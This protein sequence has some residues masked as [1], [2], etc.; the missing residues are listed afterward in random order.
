MVRLI[1]D[2]RGGR[3]IEPTRRVIPI[4][5]SMHGALKAFESSFG[6]HEMG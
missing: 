1:D 2:H 6:P 5:S 3:G 4:V